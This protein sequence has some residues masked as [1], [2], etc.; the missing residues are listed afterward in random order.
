[1]L[2]P[3]PGYIGCTLRRIRFNEPE[4]GKTF[5]FLSNQVT[6]PALTIC[7]LYKS[8]WQVELICSATILSA[9]G[10]G[11]LAETV[12]AGPPLQRCRRCSAGGRTC[13]AQSWLA[14][15]TLN[16]LTVPRDARRCLRDMQ[17]RFETHGP[18]FPEWS[19]RGPSRIS[20]PSR[21]CRL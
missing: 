11:C 3:E 10:P 12:A 7:A 4:T 17:V 2:V 18:L 20:L 5:V 9:R 14:D 19:A 6:L 8:R 1:M 21:V 16:H 15:I 13:A